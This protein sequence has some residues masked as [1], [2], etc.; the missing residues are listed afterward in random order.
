[1]CPIIHRVTTYG[2]ST[3][4]TVHLGRMTKHDVP[5]SSPVPDLDVLD[6]I[7]LGATFPLATLVGSV[8]PRL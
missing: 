5:P 4:I 1:M 3:E 7:F 2:N 6:D 8:R